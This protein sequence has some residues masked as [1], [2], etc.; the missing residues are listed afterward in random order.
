[1]NEDEIREFEKLPYF[2]DAVML[3]RWDE[4]GKIQNMNTPDFTYF[5]AAMASLE[6][7]Q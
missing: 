6:L 1:M 4:R 2:S 5:V 7:G 3:R